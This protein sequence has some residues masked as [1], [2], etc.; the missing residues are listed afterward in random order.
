MTI[1]FECWYCGPVELEV[2]PKADP[3]NPVGPGSP[4]HDHVRSEGHRGMVD[5][6]NSLDAAI[7][8]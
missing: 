8:P 4:F 7:W 6:A 1:A 3:S 5:L 2:D